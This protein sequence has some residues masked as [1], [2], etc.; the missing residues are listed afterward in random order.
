MGERLYYLADANWNTTAVVSDS[1]T[2]QERYE[3]DPYG[4]LSVFEADYT[5]RSSSNYAVHYTYTSR[6]WLPAAALYYFRN[7]WYDAQLGRF[8]SRDPLGYAGSANHLYQYVRSG[9]LIGVDPTGQRTKVLCTQTHISYCEDTCSASGK[10][11][12]G[13]ECY[14]ERRMPLLPPSRG[15][16]TVIKVKPQCRKEP[17]NCGKCTPQELAWLQ[18]GKDIACSGAGKPRPKMSCE[19]L[20]FLG[21]K[22]AGCAAA[23]QAIQ[24]KCFPGKTDKVHQDLIDEHNSRS[25]NSWSYYWSHQPPCGNPPEFPLG[26]DGPILA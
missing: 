15:N 2:V 12:F 10:V 24:T 11:A 18:M 23:R 13:C 4:D 1:G 22:N 26:P 7:R 16:P 19:R 3:Y 21:L 5:S 20:R 6:E 17:E 9:P 8:S 14:R 25:A